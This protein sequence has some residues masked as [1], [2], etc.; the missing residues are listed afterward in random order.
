M[1]DT[2]ECSAVGAEF[3]GLTSVPGG[4]IVTQPWARRTSARTVQL[5]AVVPR[6]PALDEAIPPRSCEVPCLLSEFAWRCHARVRVR[7]LCANA[8]ASPEL[9]IPMSVQCGAVS[10]KGGLNTP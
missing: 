7:P 8:A 5:L 2:N 10:L 6:T 1:D 3:I 4:R 9:V